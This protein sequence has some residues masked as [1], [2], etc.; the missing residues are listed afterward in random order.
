MLKLFF[1]LSLVL[2]ITPS[3][4]NE[5][6]PL[7]SLQQLDYQLFKSTLIKHD[8][9]VYIKSPTDIEAGKKYPTIYLIDGGITFPLLAAYS[10]YL[11]LA[12]DIPPTII[13]GISYGTT[14]WR[15]GN[16]RSTDFTAPSKEREFWGGAEKF[17]QMLSTE[18][19]PHIESTLPSDPAKRIL[20]GQSLGGQ[21]VMFNA[22]FKPDTFWGLIASNPAIH[23]NLDFYTQDAVRGKSSPNL[24]ISRARNNDKRFAEPLNQWVASQ[25]NK[26]STYQLKISWVENHN[27]FSVAP[28]SFRNGLMWL[29]DLTNKN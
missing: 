29:F 3:Q 25:D 6:N 18:L 17:S 2:S 10:R 11:E 23:R 27:H 4:A 8:Y 19:I 14:D 24:F 21:F 13:V 15:K 16:R 7:T 1:I 20:F 22:L 12:G 26:T 5:F 28:E 9:H